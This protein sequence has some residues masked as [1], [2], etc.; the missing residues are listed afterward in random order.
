[1]RWSPATQ[2]QIAAHA[3]T[4]EAYEALAIELAT[5]AAKLDAIRA[6]LEKNR[7]TTPLFDTRLFAGHLEAAYTQMYERYQADLPPEH[8]GHA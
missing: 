5:D 2:R 7:L 8:I 4:P 1:M 6:K 3:Y